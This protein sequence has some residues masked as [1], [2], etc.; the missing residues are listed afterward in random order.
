M[1]PGGV[2]GG[3]QGAPGGV[4]GGPLGV[5]GGSKRR[6]GG[7]LEGLGRLPSCKPGFEAQNC[8]SRPRSET[9]VGCKN[10]NF[11]WEW[12]KFQH[13]RFFAS[14]ALFGA[15]PARFRRPFWSQVG[16]RKASW[17]GL[18]PSWGRLGPSW[19]P[20]GPSWPALGSL[21]AA[22]G[23]LWAP[24]RRG[25][26][27]SLARAS[28]SVGGGRRSRG[29]LEGTFGVAKPARWIWHAANARRGRGGL[30]PQSGRHRR[31]P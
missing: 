29:P 14:E 6:L 9:P 17:G 27:S 25:T 8:P 3:S 26:Q 21:R 19:G 16:L 23:R 18:G 24:K 4:P 11:V 13:F 10:A 5:P 12:C 1:G 28:K 20:L 30:C 22:W 7:I 31:A 15:S 2:P